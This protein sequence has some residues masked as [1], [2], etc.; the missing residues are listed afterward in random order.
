[1]REKIKFANENGFG[2]QRNRAEFSDFYSATTPS[3][4]P[5]PTSLKEKDSDMKIDETTYK[6][7]NERL[8]GMTANHTSQPDKVLF[9]A[10][11]HFLFFNFMAA[12][13]NTLSFF[14]SLKT[15]NIRVVPNIKDTNFL[16]AIHNTPLKRRSTNA[17]V[18]NIK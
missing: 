2:S 11:P 9:F 3:A 4:R 6:D 14:S 18:P 16:K 1:M 7:R 12:A 13:Q 5:L 10:D 15:R 17:V 8:I